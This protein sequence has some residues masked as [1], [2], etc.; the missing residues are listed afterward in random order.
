MAGR[1]EVDSFDD[2]FLD[3]GIQGHRF[4]VEIIGQ[5][6]GLVLQAEVAGQGPLAKVRIQH[7]DLL[8]RI[9][10]AG[11][12]VGIHEGLTGVHAEG[13]GRDHDVVG[14]H[15]LH[16]LEVG[17]HQAHGL[18]EDALG[19]RIVVKAVLEFGFLFLGKLPVGDFGQERNLGDGLEV[20]PGLDAGVQE[21]DGKQDDGR[22]GQADE[23]RQEQ[24]PVP[25]RID[26]YA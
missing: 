5:A 26:R 25:V 15:R 18:G 11:G 7:D 21:Q 20:L 13:S 14:A 9:G 12:Q 23:E 6:V 24:R 8:A 1:D 3:D 10:Q 22:D 2:V 19:V 16:E 17:G 4:V